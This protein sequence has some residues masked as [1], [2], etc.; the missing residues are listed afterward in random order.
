MT[1]SAR[2]FRQIVIG[3]IALLV[4]G[5]GLADARQLAAKPSVYTA[6]KEKITAGN[7]KVDVVLV[8]PVTP[9]SQPVLIVFASGDGGLT[10]IS[11]ATLQHLADRGD[12]VAGV[13]SRD[14]L[15]SIRDENGRIAH[16]VALAS[17][18]SLFAQAKLALKLP[19]GTPLVVTGI[20]RGANM[21]VIA[22]GAPDVQRTIAGGVALAL[23]READ[24]L[25]MPVGME[26]MTGIQID[27]KGRVQMYP[28]IQRIGPIPFAVIQSTHDSYVPSAESRQL[29]G[30]DTATRRLYEVQSN[31]HNFG[32]GEDVMFRDLDDALMWI[33]SKR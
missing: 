16:H 10:G 26:K 28:A 30:P 31:G 3:A 13:S 8:A 24:Y 17:L 29:L 32:G 6:R 12:Y 21:A 1:G 18:T 5:T 23:T 27:E 7:L 20:S 33:T 25:D 15:K 11:K 14:A 19:A 22:A 4:A 2:A 9:K